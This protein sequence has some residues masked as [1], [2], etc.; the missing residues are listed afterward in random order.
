MLHTVDFVMYYGLHNIHQSALMLCLSLSLTPIPWLNQRVGSFL[1][2]TLIHMKKLTVVF[3][4]NTSELHVLNKAILYARDNEL[5]DRIIIA[6]VYNPV[7]IG[8]DI[9][10]RLRENLNILDHIYPKMKVDLL[11]VAAEEFNPKLVRHL[12]KE[13]GIQQSFMFIR[14]PGSGFAFN[15]GEFDG[16]RTIM[17]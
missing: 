16:V 1:R 13:L 9:R 3:F 8:S 11:L 5:C 2:D 10:T 15:I 12:S 17:K 4:A 6:H 14:C 7:S